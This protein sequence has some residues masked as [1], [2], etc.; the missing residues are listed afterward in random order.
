M[1]TIKHVPSDV[2]AA[3]IFLTNETFFWSDPSKLHRA[4]SVA[5]NV[6][7]ML[8]Q[9]GFSKAGVN[10]ISR[11]FDEAFGILKLSRI[12]RMENTDYERFQINEES[13]HYIE[14][15]VLPRFSPK[16]LES[17]ESAARIVREVCGASESNHIDGM[18]S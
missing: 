7:P 16:E 9:F 3:L 13:R 12:V 14:S 10:P 6:C 11:A 18:K 5:R 15:K 1:T 4:L 17:L 8:K 2:V